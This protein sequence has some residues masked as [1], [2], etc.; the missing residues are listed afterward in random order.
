MNTINPA[1]TAA[2]FRDIVKKEILEDGLQ[3][4][5]AGILAST[6]PASI[7]YC[8]YARAG[9]EDVGINFM[10]IN[11]DPDSIVPILSEVNSDR[12]IHGIFIYYPVWGDVRDGDIRDTVSPQ[13]DV[14]GLTSYWIRKLYANERFDGEQNQFK[15]ILPC[16]PLA[17]IKLLEQTDAYMP[18]G[19]PFRGKT[20]TVFNRSEVV[21]KPLAYMLS[22]D[23]AKIYSFDI[24]GGV[25]IDNYGSQPEAGPVTRE[26]ALRNSDVVITGVP[27]RQ[28]EKIRA[29]ELKPGAVCLN[30][31]SV[32]NFDGDAKAVAGR[33]IP[34]VGPMT[35][36]MCMRNALQLYRN[37]H[38]NG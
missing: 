4:N 9:C 22:N 1:D 29:S 27:S 3:I 14:E 37:Y 15:A 21:G 32:Q 18:Y 2:F 13:K 12:N 23:G 10:Q 31:S 8:N 30:F 38:Q 17:I 6:D 33:Y 7:T 36:A 20:I 34:R 16:T 25:V 35:V 11:A 26:M 24:H 28:F 5:I 19:L